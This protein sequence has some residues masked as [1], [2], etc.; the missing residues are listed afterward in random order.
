VGLD[1]FN[2]YK[3]RLNSLYIGSSPII[4][5]K[6][7]FKT[8]SRQ[9]KVSASRTHLIDVY[10]ITK[11][12]L[13]VSAPLEMFY[14]KLVILPLRSVARQRFADTPTTMFVVVGFYKKDFV[15]Q[16]D[17][18]HKRTKRVYTGSSPVEVAKKFYK[19]SL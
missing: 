19:L 14:N 13:P 17:R 18:N 8:I 16:L 9:S 12:L 1:Y 4:I 15:I 5:R 7:C 10:D 3:R 2:R 11:K 6:N